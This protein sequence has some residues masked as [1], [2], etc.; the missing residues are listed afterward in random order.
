MSAQIPEDSNELEELAEETERA[1]TEDAPD[2]LPSTGLLSFYDRLR[3]RVVRTLERRG[4][5]L[6][7]RAGSVLL[8]VP[9]VFMLMARLALDRGVPRATRTL[10]ASTLAYFVLP[11]DLLPEAVVGPLGYFDDVVLALT[12]LSQAFGRELEP[13]AEK[14][15]SGSRPLRTVMSDVLP[16][17]ESLLGSDLYG[18]VKKVLA[19][20]GVEVEGVD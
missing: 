20:N 15:W 1:A 14:H 9:D 12:A 5:R 7:A 17:A 11:I 13:L 19:A 8:L 4:G 3:G 6:G 18:R 16:A 10:L 2:T